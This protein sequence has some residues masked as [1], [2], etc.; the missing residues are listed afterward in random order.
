ML[1][2]GGSWGSASVLR[3]KQRALSYE[4]LQVGKVLGV[5]LYPGFPGFPGFVEERVGHTSTLANAPGWWVLGF[6]L[7]LVEEREGPKL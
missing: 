1:Q 2:A 6:G 3:G 5:G 7:C 4:M